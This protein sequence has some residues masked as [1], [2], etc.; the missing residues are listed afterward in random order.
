MVEKD[1]QHGIFLN[2]GYIHFR[3]RTV[4]NTQSIALIGGSELAK[5]GSVAHAHNYLIL[6]PISCFCPP[7]LSS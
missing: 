2:V 3:G 1:L 6:S 5:G 7:V 4:I